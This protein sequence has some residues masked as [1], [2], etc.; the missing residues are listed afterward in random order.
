MCDWGKVRCT[1]QTCPKSVPCPW[2]YKL[3]YL[4]GKCCPECVGGKQKN[5]TRFIAV[6][7][8]LGQKVLSVCQ[9]MNTY[10]YKF[11]C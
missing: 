1:E 9:Y 3:K 5:K 2:G 4:P 7:H 11:I 6:K 10:V 8:L